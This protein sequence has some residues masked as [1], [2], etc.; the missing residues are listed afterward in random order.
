MGKA[1]NVTETGKPCI[2][3]LGQSQDSDA[4]L[5]ADESVQYPSAYPGYASCQGYF[6]ILSSIIDK[7]K[8]FRRLATAVKNVRRS[9]HLETNLLDKETVEDPA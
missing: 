4:L 1:Y 9:E 3:W 6:I 8:R 7:W 5:D 2:N